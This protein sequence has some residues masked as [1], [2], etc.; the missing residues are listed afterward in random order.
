VK[1]SAHKHVWQRGEI[2][3]HGVV[4]SV[5]VCKLHQPDLIRAFDMSVFNRNQFQGP[6]E[7]RLR[8]S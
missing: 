6:I 2:R 4:I 1:Y 8:H 3:K 5:W 7:Y